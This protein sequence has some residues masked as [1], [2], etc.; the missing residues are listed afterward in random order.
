MDESLQKFADNYAIKNSDQ[1]IDSLKAKVEPFL[2][3]RLDEGFK[4]V[5]EELFP[6]ERM[7]VFDDGKMFAENGGSKSAPVNQQPKPNVPTINNK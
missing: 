6:Q 2:Q 5:R 1:I 7:Q 3:D 4:D